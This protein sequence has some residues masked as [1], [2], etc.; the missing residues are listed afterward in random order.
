MKIPLNDMEKD[1]Q[2]TKKGLMDSDMKVSAPSITNEI[3]GAKENLRGKRQGDQKEEKERKKVFHNYMRGVLLL[4]V[5]I[6]LGVSYVFDFPQAL[7]DPLIRLFRV[8]PL[9]LEYLYAIYALP[10]IIMSP[11]SGYAIERFGL[12]KMGLIF[13]FI[14]FVGQ[15]LCVYSVKVENFDYMILGRGIYGVGSEGLMTLQATI[16]E[17]WFSGR[18]LSVS[19]AV[20]Q[21]SNYFAVLSGNFATPLIFQKDRNVHTPL[22]WGSGVCLA[23][24]ALSLWYYSL[25]SNNADKHKEEEEA[26]LG[27]EEQARSTEL[28]AFVQQN[29]GANLRFG[30]GSVKYFNGTFWLLCLVTLFLA[31]SY[32]QFTNIATEMITNRFFYDYE[33]AKYFTV[34]PQIS[35]ILTSPIISKIVEVKGKKAFALLIASILMLCNF[36]VMHNMKAGK[37]NLLYVNMFIIGFG[38]SIL[39]STIYTSVALTIPKSGVSMAYSIL[40]TTENLGISIFPIFFGWLIEKRTVDS[41]NNALLSL[42]VISLCAVVAS[43]ALL[44][45]DLKRYNVLELP[46]NSRKVA[47][48]RSQINSDYIRKSFHDSQE[49]SRRDS[50]VEDEGLI[51]KLKESERVNGKSKQSSVAS[52]KK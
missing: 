4:N 27:E 15:M 5:V 8:N 12:E 46:E 9:K 32:F 13:T 39:F 7:E 47:H 17:F 48:I 21:Q 51:M 22:I 23:C 37:S 30:F 28:L 26:N 44:L 18:L 49:G 43:L 38:N 25:H 41:F 35:F 29:P 50:G 1:D 10:N 20:C 24:S 45:H 33:D 19:N 6:G 36:F 40:T 31:S 2:D 52:S 42:Q 16:N 11:I 34:V 3:K 14:S